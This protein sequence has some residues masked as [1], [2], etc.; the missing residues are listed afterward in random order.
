MRQMRLENVKRLDI[1]EFFKTKRIEAR[2]SQAKLAKF[3][4]SKED[5]ISGIE[6]GKTIPRNI[7]IRQLAN[8]FNISEQETQEC[9][10]AAK[11]N[12]MNREEHETRYIIN[13][14]NKVLAKKMKII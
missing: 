9:I 7:T 10:E 1:A 2:L 11:Q 8:F 6:T 13:F 12:R 14:A 5:T 3:V 4:G